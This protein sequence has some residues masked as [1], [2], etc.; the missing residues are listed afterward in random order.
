MW[1]RYRLSN[2]K[3]LRCMSPFLAHLG[4]TLVTKQILLTAP[5]R[6]LMGANLG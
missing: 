1:V 3:L 5:K 6:T 4:P 2:E